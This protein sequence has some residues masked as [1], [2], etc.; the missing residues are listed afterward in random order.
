MYILNLSMNIYWSFKVCIAPGYI[1]LSG[2]KVR[3]EEI[4]RW[5]GGH[6]A[7]AEFSFQHPHQGSL[8]C[9]DLQLLET[10]LPLLD[11]KAPAVLFT[12]PTHK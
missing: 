4:A 6:I 8:N 1:F 3:D 10:Q 11:N 9:L 5:L 7:L 12:R 2:V